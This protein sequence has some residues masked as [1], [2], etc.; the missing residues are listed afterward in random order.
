M[1][2]KVDEYI[3]S[4]KEWKKELIA[5]RKILSELPLQEEIKWGIPAYIYKN[6]NILGMS[7]FKNYC[8]L[9]FHHGVFL[10]DELQLLI[11]AQKDKTKD[12]RQMRFNSIEEMD[13]DIIKQYV[14][15][16]IENAE[17]GREIKLKRNTKTIIIPE[18]LQKEL[19]SNNELKNCFN[20]FTLSKQRE[21]CEYISS[22][23][24]DTT[25]QSRLEKVI[26]LI[27]NKKGLY[28]KYKNC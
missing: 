4:Q 16:A 1:N 18:E 27:L 20:D 28:D 23:K 5:L 8:G 14:I 21:F 17:A 13:L 22:T 7:T 3:A 11:N 2:R 10:K 12:L 15:E 26:P 19:S 9:W 6:K 24:R 25:K